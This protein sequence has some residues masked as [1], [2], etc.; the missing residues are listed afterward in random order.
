MLGT[1][2]RRSR[3]TGVV[4]PHTTAAREQGRVVWDH[5][6]S[7]LILQKMRQAVLGLA[8]DGLKTLRFLSLG[9]TQLRRVLANILG[10]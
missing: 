7:G 6:N 3:A 4:G 10:S 8:K 1:F 2:P 9:P 5:P